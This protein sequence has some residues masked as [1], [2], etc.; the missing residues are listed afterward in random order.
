MNSSLQST[1]LGC[2]GMARQAGLG[3]TQRRI[4]EAGSMFLPLPLG[5]MHPQWGPRSLLNRLRVQPYGR[6]PSSPPSLASRL[7]GPPTACPGTQAQIS[8]V[9][10]RAAAGK[11][12]CEG[13]AERGHSSPGGRRMGAR[14][15]QEWQRLPNSTSLPSQPELHWV[16]IEG[17]SNA[18]TQVHVAPWT[19]PPRH[20]SDTPPRPP[21]LW[22]PASPAP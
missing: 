22:Q 13:E 8:T 11:S 17:H 4:R 15:G 5:R 21:W 3:R 6:V 16:A 19:P 20:A 18:N 12:Q 1:T 2:A 14:A 9:R 10:S 7:A